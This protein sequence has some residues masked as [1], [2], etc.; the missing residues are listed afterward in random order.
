[1]RIT[2]STCRR[3]RHKAAV[4][5]PLR[6]Y[7]RRHLVRDSVSE[8]LCTRT[9]LF[10][11]PGPVNI[12]NVDT[13]STTVTITWDNLPMDEWNDARITAYE[14]RL[15]LGGNVVNPNNELV[16]GTTYNATGLEEYEEYR[17]VVLARNSVG[18]GTEVEAAP[19]IFR[20][21]EDSK[22]EKKNRLVKL[23]IA[24]S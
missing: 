21:K 24:V 17:V 6:Q 15:R 19:S 16:V 9:I 13:T 5:L 10:L 1:M 4:L 20:T 23:F 11:V 8:S 2:C 3:V 14:V 12:A 22:L 18:L 7:E